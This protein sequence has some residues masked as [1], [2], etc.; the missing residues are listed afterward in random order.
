MPFGLKNAGVEFQE[1]MNKAFDG[2]NKKTTKVYV[3]DIIVKSKDKNT[4]TADLR[5]V[6]NRLCKISLKLNP[7]KLLLAYLR[8]NV[9][10]I[11]FP[12]GG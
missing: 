8:E 6:F 10:G 1:S 11:F 7:K 4:A 3:D 9:R 2:L 12:K 5:E